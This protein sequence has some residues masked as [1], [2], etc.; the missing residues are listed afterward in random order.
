MLA[1]FLEKNDIKTFNQSINADQ[2]DLL[3][4]NLKQEI[5]DKK[6]LIHESY[7]TKTKDINKIN[8]QTA[9]LIKQC[10]KLELKRNELIKHVEDYSKL[11]SHARHVNSNYHQ[12]HQ[13]NQFIHGIKELIQLQNHIHDSRQLCKKGHLNE[14][15]ILFETIEKLINNEYLFPHSTDKF[16]QQHNPLYETFQRNVRQLRTD[17]CQ[18]HHSLW[19]DGV[20][21]TIKNQL[22]LNLNYLDQLF[23]C[24]LYDEKGE[25]VLVEK[26]IQAFASYFFQGFIHVVVEK[27]T[28]LVI[29]VDTKVISIRME[30][31][32]E[33]TEKNTIEQFNKTLNYLNQLFDTLNTYLL[34]RTMKIQMSNSKSIQPVSLMTIFS[35]TIVN[36]FIE[37]IRE[38]LLNVIP[39]DFQ[40][41]EIFRSLLQTATDF[42]KSL[43][44][45]KFFSSN[46]MS[47][48]FSSV[49]GDIDES[50]IKS[51][52]RKYLFQSR[53]LLQS[54]ATITT[55]LKTIE[56]GD[57]EQLFKQNEQDKEKYKNENSSNILL[58]TI[59]LDELDA[60]MFRFPRTIIVEHVYEY[61][62]SIRRVLQ[63]ADQLEKYGAHFCAIARNMIEL[64]HV[65]YANLHEKKA[66]EFSYLTA[67]HF[68]TYMYV[69]HECLILGEEYYHL[70]NKTGDGQPIT[71]VDYVPIFRNQAANLLKSQLDTQRDILTSFIKEIGAFHNIVVDD[72]NQDM[73]KRAINKC[74]LHTETLSHNW[75]NI[76]SPQVYFKVIGYLCDHVSHLLLKET[77][78]LED[79]PEQECQI[80]VDVFTQWSTF[81]EN[82]L[83][84]DELS[85]G[86]NILARL[87][88]NLTRFNELCLVLNSSLQ[89]IVDRWFNGQGPLASQFTALEIKQLIRALFQTSDRRAAALS[90]IQ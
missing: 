50:I 12:V 85:P 56:I 71:F 80:M 53:Q 2:I 25:K 66:Q 74:I 39:N 18:T 73:L 34:S 38:H 61:M 89:N 29:D 60:N 9:E 40:Y 49:V 54:N 3:K 55:S 51:R 21:R 20:D 46:K 24:T 83:V 52:C 77:L 48:I 8:S 64:F 87:A 26:N 59:S 6:N 37:L 17:I 28:K 27:K 16:Y 5:D 75:Q 10:E 1:E 14:A 63:E 35:T 65:I 68:N 67:L 70:K 36:D 81:L 30:N 4:S 23:K 79:I 19:N 32:E 57:D 58:S 43:I 62:Q 33:E 22:K 90:K 72:E 11:E 78:A 31:D 76:F 15:K 84:K 42:E 88:P 13:L 44:K 47:N 69:A 45:I 82:I 41:I 7:I 86:L